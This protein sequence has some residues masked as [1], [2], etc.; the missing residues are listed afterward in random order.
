MAFYIK[1]GDTSPILQAT[2]TDYNGDPVN[3]TAADVQFRMENFDGTL[4]VNAACTVTDATNGVITYT[5][6]TDDTDTAGTYKAEFE[7]T[8]SDASVET[9]PNKGSERI[10]IQ[11]DI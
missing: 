1:K 11:E 2:L 7:A 3:L 9:F 10:I 5:F 4:K 8:Y 6:T